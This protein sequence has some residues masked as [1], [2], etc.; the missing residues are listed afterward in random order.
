MTAFP[1]LFKKLLIA[2]PDAKRNGVNKETAALYQRKLSDIPD[3]VL[4]R[5]IEAYI[6]N[7]K[8]FPKI[9]ELREAARKVAKLPS[10]RF[11]SVGPG[12]DVLLENWITLKDEPF[13]EAAYAALAGKFEQAGRLSRAENILLRAKRDTDSPEARR[14]YAEAAEG[15]TGP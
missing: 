14:K 5:A 8:W 12:R 4:E 1:A 3:Q 13:D 7:G 10:A 2:F 9:A 6:D 15:D 11:D